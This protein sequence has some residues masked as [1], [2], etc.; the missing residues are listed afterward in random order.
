MKKKKSDNWDIFSENII[1]V[2]CDHF[3]TSEKYVNPPLPILTW[4]GVMILKCSKTSFF[5][6]E[7]ER[8]MSKN[9]GDIL[10]ISKDFCFLLK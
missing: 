7:F 9:E 5:Y 8:F 6:R 4:P 10:K 1:G 3:F 2:I